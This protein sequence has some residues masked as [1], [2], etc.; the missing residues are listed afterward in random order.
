M[1]AEIPKMLAIRKER[2]AKARAASIKI[3]DDW[4]DP[5]IGGVVVP[6]N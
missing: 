5:A 1:R 2:E 4:I 3:L 6:K